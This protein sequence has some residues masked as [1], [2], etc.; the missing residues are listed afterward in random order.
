MRAL[1][2][3]FSADD[4]KT[5]NEKRKSIFKNIIQSRFDIGRQQEEVN[6]GDNDDGSD[7]EGD[8]DD[9]GDSVMND[10]SEDS[11]PVIIVQHPPVTDQLQMRNDSDEDE[12][13]Q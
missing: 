11:R 4:D 5:I 9:D 13:L 8:Y 7:E 6:H 12:E 2:K 3:K 10:E 1:L